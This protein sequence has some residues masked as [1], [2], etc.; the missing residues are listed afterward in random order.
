MAREIYIVYVDIGRKIQIRRKNLNLSQEQLA[1]SITPPFT[2]AAISN[3]ERGRQ[4]IYIHT[5]YSIAKALGSTIE[6]Y[7][8]KQTEDPLRSMIEQ[9]LERQKIPQSAGKKIFQ[10]LRS[11]QSANQKGGCQL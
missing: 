1:R 11:N 5:L 9:Q 2:R 10:V 8:P 3:I 6:H 4:N 7:L